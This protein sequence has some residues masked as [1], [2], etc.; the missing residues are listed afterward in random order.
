MRALPAAL[1]ALACAFASPA[2]ADRY[3]LTYDSAAVGVIDL[4]D[5]TIDATVNEDSYEI[6]ATLKSGGLL[7]LFEPTKAELVKLRFFAGLSMPEAAAALN[8]SL[9]TA[10]RYW[11]FAKSWLYA[12]ISGEG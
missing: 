2:A 11:T 10:E 5:V 9:A 1:F 12:E 3:A 8:V 6:S 7:A 4:G